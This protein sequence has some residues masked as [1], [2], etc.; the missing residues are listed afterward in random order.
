[1]RRLGDNEAGAA[2]LIMSRSAVLTPQHGGSGRKAAVCPIIRILGK[3][4][5]LKSS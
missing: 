5:S 4:R 3:C 1:M 2:T